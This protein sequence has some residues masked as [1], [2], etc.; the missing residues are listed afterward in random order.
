MTCAKRRHYFHSVPGLSLLIQHLSREDVKMRYPAT[1]ADT[2][3]AAA[4]AD[5]A[6][7]PTP[8]AADTDSVS[9]A[10]AETTAGFSVASVADGRPAAG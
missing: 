1:T 5:T 4:T 9:I 3:T 2:D 7:A 6:P 8:T 10:A